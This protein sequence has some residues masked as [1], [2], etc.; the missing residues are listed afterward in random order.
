[1][2]KEHFQL[3]CINFLCFLTLSCALNKCM[4][5][6]YRGKKQS[7]NN[8]CS[9]SEI[10]KKNFKI[11]QIHI[12]PYSTAGLLEGILLKCC[13]RCTNITIVK[14]FVNITEVPLSTLNT[15]HFTLPF[16]GKSSA[17]T[18][19]GYHFIPIVDVPSTFYFTPKHHTIIEGIVIGCLNFYPLIIL[20]L[21]VAV[22][23]GFIVWCMET[24][25]NQEQFPRPFLSGLFEGF[26]YSF[27]S[28]TTVG[29]GDKVVKSIAAR[30]FSVIC[31]LMGIIMFS[32]L[33]SLFTAKIINASGPHDHLMIGSNVGALKFRDYD[34]SLIV[35][36]GG[37][38]KETT[39]WNFYSDVLMLIRMLK[40]NEIHGFIIDK[41]TLAYTTE[42]FLWKK[43]HTDHLL[44]KN[45]SGGETY[46]ER[47]DDIEF[48]N[49]NTYRTLKLYSGEKLSYGVLVRNIDDYNYLRDAVKDNRLVL[50]TS[51]DSELNAFFQSVKKV[52]LFSSSGIYFLHSVKLIASILGFFSILGLF[53]E[54]YKWKKIIIAAI[55]THVQCMSRGRGSVTE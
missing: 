37:V 33:T 28:M 32:L 31:I 18:L 21:L 8:N 43:N 51:V 14:E 16:L 2:S 30:L 25:S 22:I 53:Y 29:Y 39:A 48:F 1:M 41:Y 19:Y 26:W 5:V 54:F 52:N 44:S 40:N 27:A 47:K 45:M 35:E 46:N 50:E 13:G 10:C 6:D 42:Y 55:V 24:W 9:Q 17:T 49:K 12:P 23:S 15:S 7:E 4:Y 38:V 3:I 36:H 34:A 20:C 11:S